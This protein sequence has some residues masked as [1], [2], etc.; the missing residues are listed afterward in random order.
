MF[1]DRN[2]TNKNVR[3]LPLVLVVITFFLQLSTRLLVPWDLSEYVEL[4]ISPTS[5][6]D[7]TPETEDY[8]K[9]PPSE[10]L[11]IQAE[12]Q[13]ST[14]ET[15]FHKYIEDPL[16]S[17]VTD[18]L[19]TFKAAAIIK[20]RPLDNLIPLTLQ[21]SSMLGPEWPIYIFTTTET[22]V[23]LAQSAAFGRYVDTD[24][25]RIKTLPASTNF[26]GRTTPL[27]DTTN[28]MSDFL[29]RPWF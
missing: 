12:Q 7:S 19:S 2:A 25:I 29:T 13:S 5:Q 26:T 24:R 1:A 10:F 3:R 17:C 16:P 15:E 18:T 20:T 6:Q 22:I 4:A 27:N 28:M 9:E 14:P 23:H 11:I 8:V 21:F